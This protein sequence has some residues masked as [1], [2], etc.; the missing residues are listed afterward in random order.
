MIFKITVPCYDTK[1]KS[2]IVC[3]I[4]I[5]SQK[6]KTECYRRGELLNAGLHMWH[7]QSKKDGFVVQSQSKSIVRK[8]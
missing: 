3:L 2:R 1:S 8:F 6:N 5:T 4:Y 7:F